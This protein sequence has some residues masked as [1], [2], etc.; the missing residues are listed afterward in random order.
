MPYE[1]IDTGDASRAELQLWPYRSLPRRG[2]VTFILVTV[3]MLCLP[4]LGLIGSAVLW[5]LLPFLAAAVGGMW[6]ALSRSYRDGEIIEILRIGEET[7][8][9]TRHERGKPI[10]QWSAPTYWVATRLYDKN[11][12]VPKYLTLKGG[13]REVELGAFLSEDERVALVKE[14]DAELLRRR[15]AVPPS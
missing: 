4:L 10:R 8:D 9:L 12:P 1:W 6:W 13:G 7:T 14:V 5:G 2:F 15:Q 3:A 11:M